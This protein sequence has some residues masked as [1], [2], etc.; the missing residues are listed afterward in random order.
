M[1]LYHLPVHGRQWLAFDG[2]RLWR[3]QAQQYTYCL[4]FTVANETGKGNVQMTW[5]FTR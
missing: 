4:S 5:V 1:Q 2:M 3:V